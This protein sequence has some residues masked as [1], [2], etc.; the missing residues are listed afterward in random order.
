MENCLD[1][2]KE[3][4]KGFGERLKIEGLEVDES[5]DCY[6]A[7]DEK[8]YVKCSVYPEKEQIGFLAYIGSMPED[9]A[10]YYRGLLESNYF[11]R[12]T[13]GGNLSVDPSDGT[14]LL[15]HYKD[16]NFLNSELF[17]KTMEDF[18]NAMEHWDTK[19]LQEWM[20]LTED[21]TPS[22][23]NENAFGSPGMVMLGV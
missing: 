2:F 9:G 15:V 3:Y 8:Y 18:V 16:M 6:L 4:I 7:F 14:L 17:Y 11:W 19:R 20:D 1:A 12:D 13:A 21:T 10:V 23:S 5:N 22:P